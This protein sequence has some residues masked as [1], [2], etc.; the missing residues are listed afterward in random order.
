MEHE[1]GGDR[2]V[3]IVSALVT[4]LL[5]GDRAVIIVSAL[6]APLLG[7]DRAVIIVSALV[8]PLLGGDR[9]VIIVSA[10]VAPLL[11]CQK[12]T[13]VQSSA[14]AETTC[15]TVY[16]KLLQLLNGEMSWKENSSL[17]GLCPGKRT[18][19][20]S[21]CVLEREQSLL[22]LWPYQ[23]MKHTVSQNGEFIARHC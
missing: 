20:F 5:G 17:L 19:L 15:S 12:T 18:V 1:H 11:Q 4:P 21:D 14:F 6:V 9:A 2:A 13:L 3:I 8:T 22:G 16:Q 23:W 10:L 7:G